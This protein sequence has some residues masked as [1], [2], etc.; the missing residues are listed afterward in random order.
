MPGDDTPPIVRMICS[1]GHAERKP[2]GRP[3]V[4]APYPRDNDS[5]ELLPVMNASCYRAPLSLPVTT[6]APSTPITL[7]RATVAFVDLLGA[8]PLADRVGIERA[9]AVVTGA[10]RLLEGIARR[11]G[12]VVD[13]YLSDA[14][15][16]VFGFPLEA[17]EPEAAAV[18]AGLE[19]LDAIRRYAPEVESP[20]PLRLRIGVNTGTMVAGDL[21]GPVV[22]E[23]RV[24]GDPV[25]VA[26]RLKDLGSPG[27]IH[28]GPETHAAARRSFEFDDLEP[29]TLRGKRNQLRPFRARPTA[30]NGRGST[31]G[32]VL[33]GTPL[34]GRDRELEAIRT[35][36][37]A[38]SSGHGAVVLLTG[39]E[40]SGKSRL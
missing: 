9:Y 28:V 31:R 17:P 10:L 2:S 39:A 21:R 34:I 18:A 30:G 26:A 19:M 4:P 27:C 25:N 3:S 14:L 22:C 12:A 16:A 11:H 40:G 15:M 33:A 23:F 36:L 35:R 20:V 29:L 8:G 38:L 6:S 1:P 32:D 13:K 37:D 5:T 7:R 24:L